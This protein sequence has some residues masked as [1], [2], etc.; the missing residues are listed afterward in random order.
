VILAHSIAVLLGEPCASM[1]IFLV[2]NL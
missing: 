1:M 2:P